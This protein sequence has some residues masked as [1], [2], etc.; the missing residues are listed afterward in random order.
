MRHHISILCLKLS[1]TI[2]LILKVKH[3][4]TVEVLKCLYYPL[5]YP[6]LNYCCPN[7]YSCHLYHPNV[8]HKN[9]IRIMTNSQYCQPKLPILKSL[10]LLC[11]TDLSRY[12]IASHMYTQVRLNTHNIQPLHSYANRNQHLM[13]IPRHK[14]TLFRHS[15][16]YLEPKIWNDNPWHIKNFTNLW[17]FKHKLKN[18]LISFK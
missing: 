8:L 5:I 3:F 18:H 11:L 14:L 12:N 10:N 2:P 17:L 6:H 13:R 15:L 16:M 7:T 1:R 9:A 4:A